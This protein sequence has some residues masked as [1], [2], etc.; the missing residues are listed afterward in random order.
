MK[1]GVRVTV[2]TMFGTLSSA[3]LDEVAEGLAAITRS[4]CQRMF[5]PSPLNKPPTRTR[6][7]TTTESTVL[8]GQKIPAGVIIVFSPQLLH[9]RS[10]LYPSPE[11]FDPDRWNRHGSARKIRHAGF[12]PFSGEARKCIGDV[13]ALTEAALT[14]ATIVKHRRLEPLPSR[15]G[16]SAP[17]LGLGIRDSGL[18]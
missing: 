17:A 12:L 7:T 6:T 11:R 1:I 16:R 8:G 15:R 4:V 9:H 3:T 2:A 13:F 14:L 5:M 10:D 18:E